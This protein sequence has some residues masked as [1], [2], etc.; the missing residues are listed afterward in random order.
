M[1]RKSI[2]H[3]PVTFEF[4]KVGPDLQVKLFQRAFQLMED[5]NIHQEAHA[6]VGWE[7]LKTWDKAWQLFKAHYDVW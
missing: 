5:V 3:Y 7:I 2:N 1:I 4:M 6:M